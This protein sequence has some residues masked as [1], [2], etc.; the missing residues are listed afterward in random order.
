MRL[1]ADLFNLF[2]VTSVVNARFGSAAAAMHTFALAVL[3]AH[4]AVSRPVG[5]APRLL[6]FTALTAAIVGV[7]VVG[8]RLLLAAVLPGPE[9]ASAM[10]DRLRVTGP[11]GRLAEIEP[12]AATPSPGPP[13][14]EQDGEHD[15]RGH[16]VVAER[17]KGVAGDVE[18][19][20][21]D[22]RLGRVG[23]RRVGRAALVQ[24]QYE[25]ADEQERE[26]HRPQQ[27]ECE[28]AAGQ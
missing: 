1:P 10:F 4:L 26:A 24:R 19:E 12:L 20:P 15:H 2:A 23:D 8:S 28:P 21:V 25:R 3:G 6:R 16:D 22:R 17:P 18:L 27:Q 13:E 11:R 7:F 14:A 9:G 5:G